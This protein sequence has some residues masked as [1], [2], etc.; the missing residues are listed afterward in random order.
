MRKV[1]QRYYL[2]IALVIMISGATLINADFTE[3]PKWHDASEISISIP[4][5]GETV[6]LEDAIK[7][8]YLIEG[9]TLVPTSSTNSPSILHSADRVVIRIDG[10]SKTLQSSVDGLCPDSTGGQPS[11]VSASVGEPCHLSTEIRVTIDNEEMSLQQAIDAGKFC[12]QCTPACGPHSTCSEGSCVCDDVDY[13]NCDGDDSNGCEAHLPDDPHNCG[14]CDNECVDGTL[15]DEYCLEWGDAWHVRRKTENGTCSNGACDINNTWIDKCMAGQTKLGLEDRPLYCGED[16]NVHQDIETGTCT[17]TETSAYCDTDT[18]NVVENC[19]GAGCSDRECGEQ[20]C[21]L[22]PYGGSFCVQ[23]Y[24]S[25][26]STTHTTC[27]YNP[28]DPCPC[29]YGGCTFY[30]PD[31]GCYPYNCRVSVYACM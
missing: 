23:E 3:T 27:E 7:N 13:D 4:I 2:I 17:E 26:C 25:D 1:K 22:K 9:S 8:G 28:G 14:I 21:T 31:Y 18:S 5:D 19:G 11:C 12:Q 6:S 15:V 30:E 10:Q 29:D 16:G 20:G 24:V